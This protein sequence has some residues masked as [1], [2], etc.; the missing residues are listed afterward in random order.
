LD[1]DRDIREEQLR[2]EAEANQTAGRPVDG[3][4]LDARRGGTEG[5]AG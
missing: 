2:R 3:S 1:R 5:A 4:P